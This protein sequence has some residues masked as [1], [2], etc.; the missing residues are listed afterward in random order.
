MRVTA[1]NILRGSGDIIATIDGNFIVIDIYFYIAINL[2]YS[3]DKDTVKEFVGRTASSRILDT[4][5]TN[6]GFTIDDLMIYS[7][8]TFTSN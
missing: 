1:L 3:E 7:C 4:N 6:L 8:A 2:V 5:T